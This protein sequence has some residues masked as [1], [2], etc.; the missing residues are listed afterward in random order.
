MKKLYLVILLLV[1]VGCSRYD[2]TVH[3]P[4]VKYQKPNKKALSTLLKKQLGK[5]YVWAEE[6]PDEFDCSGLTYYCYGSMNMTIPR[7]ARE[8]FLVGKKISCKELEY[9]D[10]IFFDTT[11][12]RSGKVTHVG[13]YIGDGKFEHA[14][15]EK[16]GV[17]ITPIDDKYYS[18]RIL[19]CR[20]YIGNS[21]EVGE[22]GRFKPPTLFTKPSLKMPKKLTSKSGR[23][24]IQIGSYSS[25]PDKSYLTHLSSF[26]YDYKVSK[27][28]DKYKLLVGPFKSKESAKSA[29]PTI[30]KGFNPSSF[31]V[32]L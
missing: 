25:Y 16:E 5:N 12:N 18:K 22:D 19:G 20:R 1:G 9:G 24:Y 28:S 6:G 13:V 26:G 14:A 30:K 23:Y 3:K 27:K 31:I 7:V 17:T 15:N 4:K 8:Q 10:L 21:Y 11:P 29:L 32:K 2:Y